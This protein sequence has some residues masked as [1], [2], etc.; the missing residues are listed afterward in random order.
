MYGFEGFCTDFLKRHPGYCIYPIR[1][2][3][4]A[5]ESLFSQLKYT[6][7]GNLMATNYASARAVILTKGSISARKRGDD[8]RD[9]PLYI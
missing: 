9:A 1:M 3:G 5:V 7:G 4:S 6:T 2:N 8:Y